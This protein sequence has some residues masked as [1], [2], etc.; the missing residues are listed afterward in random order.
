MINCPFYR[1]LGSRYN[2]AQLGIG[3]ITSTLNAAG[4]DAWTYNA[5]YI[6]EDKY[7]NVQGLFDEYHNYKEYFEKPDEHQIWDEVVNK[8]LEFQ[9]DWVGWFCYTASVPA[10]K[11][12]SK[13]LKEKNS[14]IKQVVGGPHSS[15]DR[16]LLNRLP[17]IDFSV[18]R[19]GEQCML[20]LVNGD[21]PKTIHGVISRSLLGLSQ[22]G[23]ADFLDR[24]ILP[25]PEREKFWGL[26]EEEKLTVD[27]SYIIR[28]I[29]CPYDCSYCAS[30]F[31]W[32]RK[33]QM[34]SNESII[35]EAKLVKEKYWNRTVHKDYSASANAT[36][37]NSLVIKSNEILYFVDDIFP[38]KK[39]GFIPL[40]DDFVKEKLNIPWK[41]ESRADLLDEEICLKMQ[42]A[43]CQMIKIGF[44]SASDRILKQISKR[45]T[46]QDYINCANILKKVGMK[47][48]CY[49]M[50]GFEDEHDV[51]VDET[52]SFAKYLYDMGVVKYFSLSIL[53]PYFGTPVYFDAISRGYDLDDDSAWNLFYH[54]T[55]D[56]MINKHISKQ[57]VQ[58]F[59]DLGKLNDYM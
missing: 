50:I 13:K 15:M 6:S 1:L 54:Q 2:A 27:V 31:A 37:K 12:L 48:G 58:E 40:M 18:V 5:D 38:L 49:F 52:I 46:R 9:P 25:S 17:D 20:R 8:I 33:T 53:S 34:R 22:N 56:L 14:D 19:E 57:K 47:V 41:C 29:S 26:T 3:Y 39:R 24:D 4:H 11:I 59:L 16:E 32:G 35:S 55:G 10:I 21:N 45:E 36:P 7:K 42:E 30:P 23:D 44:E 43:G 51:D 28:T